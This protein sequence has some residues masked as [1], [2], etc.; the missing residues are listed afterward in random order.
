MLKLLLISNFCLLGLA[1]VLTFSMNYRKMSFLYGGF[2]KMHVGS[3]LINP[4][5]KWICLRLSKS[6]DMASKYTFWQSTCLTQALVARF[7]CAVFNVPYMLYIGYPKSSESMLGLKA[8]AWVMAGPVCISGGDG[9]K[10]HAV[11][12]SYSNLRFVS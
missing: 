11:V 9:F 8:H 10:N 4:Q 7:W 2:C 5:K 12:E 3:T 1:R 6:I